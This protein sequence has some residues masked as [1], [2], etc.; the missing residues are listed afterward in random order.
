[1][2]ASGIDAADPDMTAALRQAGLPVDDLGTPGHSFFRFE[3]GGS[4][5][6]F[7]GYEI[8]GDH[9]L[10]RSLVIVPDRR[11]EGHGR[12]S[13]DFLLARLAR[14]GL[15]AAFLLTTD[16][17]DFF[18]RAGFEAIER[19]DAPAAI[20]ATRQAAGLCPASATLMR[21]SLRE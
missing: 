17:A 10:L 7:G 8:H 5:I 21:R 11:G 18:A 19:H 14:A 12:A 9:A 16:R 20:R 6:G 1:M 2:N 13:V 15:N 3:I 4:A